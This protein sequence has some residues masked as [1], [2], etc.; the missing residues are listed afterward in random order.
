MQ[1]KI[2]ILPISMQK[3][4]RNLSPMK[5]KKNYNSHKISRCKIPHNSNR[6]FFLFSMIG[7]EKIFFMEICFCCIYYSPSLSTI[8][9]NYKATDAT[10]QKWIG[11]LCVA[12][13]TECYVCLTIVPCRFS[14]AFRSHRDSYDEYVKKLCV[15][16]FSLLLLTT[17]IRF[18]PFRCVTFNR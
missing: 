17:V 14:V 15:F 13:T 10:N 18:A 6:I 7:N 12:I 2:K 1:N 5:W 3:T 9:K 8:F 4:H 11:I 16:F